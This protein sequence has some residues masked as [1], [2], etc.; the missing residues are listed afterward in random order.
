MA[1]NTRITPIRGSSD[2]FLQRKLFRQTPQPTLAVLDGIQDPQ[3]LGAVIRSAEALGIHGIILPRRRTAPLNETVAKC[4]SGALETI[5]IAM[6]INLAN[7][8][9]LLKKHGFWVVGVDTDGKKP[10]YRLSFDS[11]TAL[12]I[13]SEG[14][15]I[16]P[17]LKRACD[18]TVSIPMK[19]KVGSLNVSAASA[20]LFYEIL[21]Q[22]R[23]VE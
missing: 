11:P 17:L 8:L 20:V 23:K 15:G 3:N 1:G 21:R 13:G 12:L 18:F 4:S 19:G 10:C 16:R 7:A 2:I 6:A 9:K 22:K 5:P 14:K